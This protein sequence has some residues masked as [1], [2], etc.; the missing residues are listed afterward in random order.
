M[1]RN[2]AHRHTS[3][4]RA[5]PIAQRAFCGQ[6]PYHQKPPYGITLVCELR[7]MPNRTLCRVRSTISAGELPLLHLGGEIL[8]AAIARN[9]LTAVL[10]RD[11]VS[12]HCATFGAL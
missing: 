12:S 3:Q 10:H 8:S 5:S 7:C 4:L 1:I 6:Q 9:D 11:L 2:G